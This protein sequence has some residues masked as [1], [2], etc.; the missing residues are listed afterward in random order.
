MFN[1]M[2][3]YLQISRKGCKVVLPVVETDIY[4]SIL[5]WIQK[6]VTTTISEHSVFLKQG[7]DYWSLKARRAVHHNKY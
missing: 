6:V 5:S 2:R 7:S 3:L 4:L 1:E